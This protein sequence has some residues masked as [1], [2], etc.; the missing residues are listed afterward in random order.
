VFYDVPSE[1]S[2]LKVRLWR[3]FKKMGAIYPHMSICVVP[4]NEYN[5]KNLG[6]LEKMALIDG[7]LIKIYGKALA[8]QDQNE[9]LHIFRV[10][11]DKQYDE[12]L[13][14]CQ[15][16]I[17]EIHLNIK[18]RKTSQE[19]VEEMEEALDGLSRWLG[20]VKSIDWVENSASLK[21]VEKLLEK[22]EDMLHK[23]IEVSYPKKS[24]YSHKAGIHEY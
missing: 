10:E 3:D 16:Y 7:K 20:R 15:E 12:I 9:I 23:F 21:R 1:P 22:C 24:N 13:E 5:R 19:E 17:D 8:E 11:R 18:G 6:R 4:D 2:K 14:E